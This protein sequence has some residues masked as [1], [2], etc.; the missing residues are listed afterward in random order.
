MV[1]IPDQSEGS[2]EWAQTGLE[3]ASSDENLKK[4]DT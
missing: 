4:P 2:L 1:G 3:K